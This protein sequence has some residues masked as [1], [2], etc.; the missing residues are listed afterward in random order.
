[1]L[2]SYPSI[3]FPKDEKILS[4]MGGTSLWLYCKVNSSSSDTQLRWN[5]NEKKIVKD[6]PRIYTTHYSRGSHTIA[7]LVV[8]GLNIDDVGVYR[9]SAKDA[10]GIYKGRSITF[11]GKIASC[12]P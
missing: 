11:R 9:C 2:E 7:V 10:M 4:L 3:F 5:R 6:L 8:K 1:L 12:Q